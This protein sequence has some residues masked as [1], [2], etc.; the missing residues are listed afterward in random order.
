MFPFVAPKLH[1]ATTRW[2]EL[3]DDAVTR[4]DKAVLNKSG[5]VSQSPAIWFVVRWLIERLAKDG[6]AGLEYFDSV[7]H[8][9]V[10]VLHGLFREFAIEGKGLGGG[11]KK[12]T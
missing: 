9:S 1:R 12:K 10:E 2:R 8:D 3:W 4:I 7:G 11:G 6:G 5:M